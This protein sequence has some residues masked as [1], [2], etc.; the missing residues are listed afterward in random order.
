M[1]DKYGYKKPVQ[2][3]PKEWWFNGCFI[4][5]QRPLY[6]SCLPSFVVFADSDED[7]YTYPAGS[8][9]DAKQTAIKVGNKFTTSN[10]PERF[11]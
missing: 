5:D 6:R 9:L 7:I 2:L 11:L 3:D 8:F 10:R 4:Q 1:K